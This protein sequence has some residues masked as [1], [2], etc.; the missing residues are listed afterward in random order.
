MQDQVWCK[1]K[2]EQ[3]MVLENNTVKMCWDFEYAMRKE[4]TARRLD[5]TL[6][7]KE[8]KVIQLVDMACPSEKNVEE[9]RAEKR[10]KYQQL[11]FEI[12]ERRKGYRVEV[13]PV[14][15]GCMG[16]RVKA[17]EEQ[18]R[19]ILINSNIEKVCREMLRTTIMELESILRKVIANIVTAD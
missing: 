3:G 7:Y 9:K 12:R 14:V 11:A 13:V 16:G 8:R 17:M 1:V 6:E 15:I 10:Q 19:K 4:S 5:V 2:W 18:V